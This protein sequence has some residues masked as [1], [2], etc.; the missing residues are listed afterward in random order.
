MGQ[1]SGGGRG[2]GLL[3]G[4]GPG[5]PA[6]QGRISPGKGDHRGKPRIG[7][8]VCHCGINIAGVVDVV[9]VAEYARTLPNVVYADHY[10]F[11]CSTDSLDKMRQVIETENLN[12][13]VVASCS[14]RTHEPL[15]QE[16]LRKAGLNKYLFEM[17]NIRDQDSWVHQGTPELATEKAKELVRMSMARAAILE[18]LSDLLFPVSQTG[19]GGGRRPGRPDGGPDH[20][21]RRLPGLP[22]GSA[23]PAGRQPGPSGCARTLEGHEVQPYLQELVRPGGKPPPH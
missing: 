12:R 19:P 1:A 21:R 23:G 2:G 22:G 6:H 15:F 4:R 20:C 7:V 3:A 14:P 17:A 10:T 18:P 13:V 16:N 9:A 5:H 11:T 8:F